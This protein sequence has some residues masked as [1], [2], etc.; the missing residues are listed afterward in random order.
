M[1]NVKMVLRTGQCDRAHIYDTRVL[2]N[3]NSHAYAY[4]HVHT[5]M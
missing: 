2:A 1:L 3:A 4:V 5:H